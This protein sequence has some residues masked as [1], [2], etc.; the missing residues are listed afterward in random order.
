MSEWVYDSI[1]GF[2]QSPLWADPV[3][4]FVDEKCVGEIHVHLPHA[5][6]FFT[7]SFLVFDPEEE[8]KLS[9]HDIF[10]DYQALVNMRSMYKV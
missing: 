1:V 5:H 8:N 7:H 3:N 9:Y 10:K 4:S 6:T 2:L